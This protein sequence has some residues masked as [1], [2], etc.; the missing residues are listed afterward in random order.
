MQ[1]WEAALLGVIQGLTEFIPVSSDGHIE[2]LKVLLGV[3]KESDLTFTI[4]LHAGTVGS[5][6]VV[7]YKDILSLL[8]GIFLRE[9][10]ALRF[11]GYV[12]ISMIPVGIV[13]LGF[14]DKVEALF[15]GNLLLTG[16]MLLVSGTFLAIAHFAPRGE[17]SI[18]P[19][20][21]LVMG[22]AQAFAVLPGLSRS[23][24]TIAAAVV[25]KA[26]R[27][28]I[29]RF[30]FLMVLPV[31]IGATLLEAIKAARAPA[32]H[33]NWTNW[34]IGFFVSF[35]VGL[36]ACKFM[37]K[38]VGKGNF[39]GFAIYCFVLGSVALGIGFFK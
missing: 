26:D 30:S 2:L 38:V 20:M 21:A 33:I 14:K 5:T 11:A 17:R 10:D 24:S 35:I 15:N 8:K 39:I 18:N 6:L 23:G 13:G 25:L 1:S 31:I 9:P 19:K 36:F 34:A 4:V 37:I 28:Y 3:E 16:A 7:F 32:L 12:L 22:V 29:A 27:A